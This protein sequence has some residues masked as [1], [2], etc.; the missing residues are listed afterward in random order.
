MNTNKKIIVKLKSPKMKFSAGH[1][2]IFSN[3]SRENL[4]GHNFTVQ[5]SIETLIEEN[6]MALD[7]NIYKHIIID[8]CNQL[9]EIILLPEKSP[10]MRLEE[11]DTYYFCHFFDER[12]V[13]L[14]RDVKFLPVAN[15]TIEE[16]A[17]W[18]L[19]VLLSNIKNEYIRNINAIK[20][21]I[22]SSPSQSAI[23]KWT[24]QKCL[25]P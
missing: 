10:H 25:Q 5:C 2:T 9:D 3:E 20:I 6:G 4:H 21:K 19:S 7:Y 12:M 15:I 18:M 1:F 13:F 24:K 16:L 23:A 8:I 17:F 22:S 14:K 11:S